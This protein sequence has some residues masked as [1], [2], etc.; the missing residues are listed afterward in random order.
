MK[1]I[2]DEKK[3][4]V[5]IRIITNLEEFQKNQKNLEKFK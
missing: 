2:N 3:L 4:G 1:F 5:N